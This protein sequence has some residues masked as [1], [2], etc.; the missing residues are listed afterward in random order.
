MRIAVI[1]VHSIRT[2]ESVRPADTTI[3][4]TAELGRIQNVLHREG[5]LLGGGRLLRCGRCVRRRRLRRAS[6]T[7]G[8]RQID[9]ADLICYRFSQRAGS[10]HVICNNFRIKMHLPLTLLRPLGRPHF[11]PHHRCHPPPALR[12]CRCAHRTAGAAGA[13]VR[14]RLL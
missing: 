10:Q 9:G 8:S 6:L 2:V 7:D 4:T 5:Q 12:C 11:A 14:R 1:V 3:L 13:G